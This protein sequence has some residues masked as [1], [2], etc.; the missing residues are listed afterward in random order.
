MAQKSMMEVSSRKLKVALIL[1][2]K[3]AEAA[4]KT[5]TQRRKCREM[6]SYSVL[7]SNL[8]ANERKESRNMS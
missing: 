8:Y 2:W 5:V 6:C 3:L 7:P 1:L 4:M